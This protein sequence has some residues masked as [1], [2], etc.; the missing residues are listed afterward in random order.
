QLGRGPV[1]LGTLVV[2]LGRVELE[3]DGGHGRGAS[4]GVAQ[5]YLF[6]AMNV[7]CVDAPCTPRRVQ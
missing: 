1:Q 4:A 6:I 5:S 7:K 2:G 3:A